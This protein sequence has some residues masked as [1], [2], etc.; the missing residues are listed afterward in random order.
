[1]AL[2][3]AAVAFRTFNVRT[4]KIGFFAKQHSTRAFAELSQVMCKKELYF[5]KAFVFKS[6]ISGRLL[7][8]YIPNPM[9]EM[10]IPTLYVVLLVVQ[11][12]HI[13]CLPLHSQMR[14]LA[15]CCANIAHTITFISLV[16]YVCSFEYPSSIH[17]QHI[18]IIQA[19]LEWS[20]LRCVSY[21]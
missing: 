8:F 13:I 19:I 6:I 21:F 5:Q 14:L 9:C 17:L 7:W 16:L 2:F 20:T 10:Y 15:V 11:Y 1:M 4:K 12:A 18:H 3:A